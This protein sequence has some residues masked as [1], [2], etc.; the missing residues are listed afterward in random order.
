MVPVMLILRALKD[1][2]DK[3]IFERIT[4]GKTGNTFLTDRVEL[5]LRAF[6]RYSVHTQRQCLGYIGSKFF[7]MLDSPE[8]YTEEQV[9]IEFLKKII[10]VHLD[11][12]TDKFNLLM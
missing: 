12:N 5:L 7:V 10:L 9:G 8:D 3:E 11:D 4:M 2:S 1:A 6:Q